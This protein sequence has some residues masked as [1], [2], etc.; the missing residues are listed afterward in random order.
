MQ[1]NPKTD[2]KYS[3]CELFIGINSP[4]AME[5]EKEKLSGVIEKECVLKQR[6]QQE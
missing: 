3:D 6:C 2:L 1:R 4:I 5:K